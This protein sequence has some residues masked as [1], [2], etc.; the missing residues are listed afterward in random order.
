MITFRGKAFVQWGGKTGKKY[1]SALT[2]DGERMLVESVTWH[3]AY[4]DE[5][6]LKRTENSKATD[7]EIAKQVLAARERRIAEIRAGIFDPV[8]E[9]LQK[10]NKKPVKAHINDY[11]TYLEHANQ[12]AYH[13]QVTIRHLDTAIE[14]LNITRISEMTPERA[15]SF[16]GWLRTE[17]LEKRRSL[18]GHTHRSPRT[19]NSYIVSLKSFYR[20]LAMT[21]RLPSHPIVNL[22]KLPE[23]T[24]RRHERRAITR[25]EFTKLFETTYNNPKKVQGIN[26]PTRATIYLVAAMT[27]LRRQ[28]LASLTRDHFRLDDPTPT[29][30]I[31]GAY[32]KN[33]KTDEIPLHPTVVDRLR[34]Y[35]DRTKPKASK[36]VFPLR[37]PG[38][39]LRSTSKMMQRDCEA[40]GIDYKT[41]DGFVDFH[42][43]RVLFITS[44]CRSNIG[45]VMAQK[46]ARHSDPKLTSNIYSKVSTEERAE[47]IGA[48][49]LME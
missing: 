12:S 45:L 39:G 2:E 40:A 46:L 16:V 5:H 3:I 38:G 9:R 23:D 33:K 34:E 43:N 18:N 32:S 37:S 1:K 48:I 20:W 44:L 36:P 28:E 15:M 21:G 24:D 41:S 29:V 19:V 42:A 14:F 4:V 17:P 6:G 10:A 25:E 49:N 35:F 31:K 22:K 13:I 27:G 11:Q 8:A 26:G 7:R 30:C 47:A